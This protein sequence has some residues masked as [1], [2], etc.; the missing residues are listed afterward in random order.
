[1]PSTEVVLFIVVALL[2]GGL[3]MGGVTLV[4]FL[5]KWRADAAPEPARE[6]EAS[7][8]DRAA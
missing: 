3:T 8:F 5:D 2:A 6:R 1:M 4:Y 7:P